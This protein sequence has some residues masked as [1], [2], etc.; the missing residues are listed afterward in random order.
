MRTQTA[1]NVTARAIN[2]I[3]VVDV[4]KT[5]LQTNVPAIAQRSTDACKCLPSETCV[6]II[7]PAWPNTVDRIVMIDAS[8]TNTATN[9]T[10]Q[11]IVIAKVKHAVEHETECI[12]VT[13]HIVPSSD[14][15]RRRTRKRSSCRNADGAGHAAGIGFTVA[16][17]GFEA[18]TTEV[19]SDNRT[20]IIT[21]FMVE[22]HSVGRRSD[23]KLLVFNKHGTTIYTHIP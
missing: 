15:P 11:T 17:F 9:E 2:Q 4:E 8:H 18:E 21:G 12:H 6:R 23:V 14:N 1:A 19:V 5:I 3:D 7:K 20:K 22:R 16:S 13:S 10:L